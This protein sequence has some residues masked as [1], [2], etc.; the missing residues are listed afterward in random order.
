MSKLLVTH[1]FPHRDDV[2]GLWLLRRFDPVFKRSKMR[3]IPTS[4]GG[5][6]LPASQIGVGVG[7]GKYDEHK[8][9]RKD[10]AASLIW[11]DLKRRGKLPSGAVGR[12]LAALIEHVRL[13]DL[14]KDIGSPHHFRNDTKILQTIAGLPGKDSL[15]ATEWGFTM[16]DALLSLYVEREQAA[17]D[18]RK[19]TKFMTR[20]GR[21]VAVR[22]AV[23]PGMMTTVSS[24]M[25]NV[26][27]ILEHPTRAYLHVRAT[28]KS[29]ANLTDLAKHVRAAEPDNEWY[30][31]HSKKMLLHGDLVAPTSKR[32]RLTLADMTTLVK[33]CYGR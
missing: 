8:G 29:G 23:L 9:D 22:S 7:R 15:K 5:V 4:A 3:F 21:G 25:G 14:G 24:E 31:H 10:S 16:L 30:F 33:H 27:V 28:P 2:A 1:L 18:V 19:G 26:I 12:G 32:T 17:I 13:G 20:W 11:K 6:K